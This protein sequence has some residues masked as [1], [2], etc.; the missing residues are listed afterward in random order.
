MSEEPANLI[1]TQDARDLISGVAADL[2]NP[3]NNGTNGWA[4]GVEGFHNLTGK[5]NDWFEID[6]GSAQFCVWN[7]G[8]EDFYIK[9]NDT[10]AAG[11]AIIDNCCGDDNLC[12]G[13][14]NM[15]T[16]LNLTG[17]VVS[18]QPKTTSCNSF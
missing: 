6:Q 2:A 11:Q 7:M 14:I 4:N 8:N 5:I 3:N 9:T 13:G 10:L 18:L 1:T 12:A 15:I 17:A 16:G